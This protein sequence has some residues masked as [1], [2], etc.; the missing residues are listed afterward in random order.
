M[1]KGAT[2]YNVSP[3]VSPRRDPYAYTSS[4]SDGDSDNMED[5]DTD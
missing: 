4:E 5:F 1:R 2:L 3:C